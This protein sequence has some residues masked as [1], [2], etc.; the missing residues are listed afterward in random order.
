MR[1]HEVLDWIQSLNHRRNNRHFDSDTGSI[2][3]EALHA[4]HLRQIAERTASAG[5]HHVGDRT[6]RVE[7]FSDF[8]FHFLLRTLPDF[9]GHA[10]FLFFR[11]EAV[12]IVSLNGGHLS[13]SIINDACFPFR[14][15]DIID[16]PRNARAR[17]IIKAETLHFVY[18][19]RHRIKP[20]SSDTIRH[21]ARKH[22]LGDS[23][24]HKRI[25]SRQD[26]VEEKATDGRL[27]WMSVEGC[28][29]LFSGNRQDH[30]LRALIDSRVLGR[31]NRRIR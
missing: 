27:K 17:C 8:L 6:H 11:E 7:L 12:L 29:L 13:R 24:V 15:R 30:N 18:D 4:R 16:S 10:T 20:I 26:S 23:L 22:F 3:D 2:L 9:D 19:I 1:G 31:E 5:L 28:V 21:D 14:H 25:V